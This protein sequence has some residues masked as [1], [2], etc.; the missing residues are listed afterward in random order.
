MTPSSPRLSR[1]QLLTAMTP[2]AKAASALSLPY[3]PNPSFFRSMRPQVPRLNADTWSLTLGG[4]VKH[5][6]TWSYADLM[7]LPMTEVEATLLCAANEPGGERIGHARW[8]GVAVQALLADSR[9]EPSQVIELRNP[10]SGPWP[11]GTPPRNSYGRHIVPLTSYFPR[12]ENAEGYITSIPYQSMRDALIAFE[13]NGEALTAE[14]GFPA[15]LIVPGLYD[16]KM[17]RWIE[18]IE[19][20]IHPENGVWENNGYPVD[21]IVRT[22]AAITSH[23]PHETVSSSVTLEGY[24]FAGLRAVAS[25]EVSVDGS[26]WTSIPFTPGPRGSWS[27]W[28][29]DW[30]PAAAGDHAVAVRATDVNGQ[31]QPTPHT[32]VLR[33]A[34]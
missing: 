33:V 13:M 17:P 19:L 9:V 12:L 22:T 28:S 10:G 30:Q 15:R 8:R 21:G 29:L 27:R 6:V 3:T 5:P 25:V 7:A 18:R 16:Y 20:T 2:G 31:M 4:W 1:R 14:Q 24:A 26:E 23:R 34:P 11:N 32:L